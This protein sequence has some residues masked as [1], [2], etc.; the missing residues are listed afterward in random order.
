MPSIHPADRLP[1]IAFC[2]PLAWTALPTSLIAQAQATSAQEVPVESNKAV[3]AAAF[4]CWAVGGSG[5]FNE[6]LA[7]NVVWTIEGSGPSAAA[8]RVF[9]EFVRQ[10]S[11]QGGHSRPSVSVS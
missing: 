4:D 8:L 10:H 3:V 7:P 2:V 1:G 11:R 9:L 6:V 5:F